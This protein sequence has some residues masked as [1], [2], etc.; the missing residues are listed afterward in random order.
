MTATG[1]PAPDGGGGDRAI[2]VTG[3][4][5]SGTSLATRALHLLGVSLGDEDQLMDAGR[6]NPAGYWENRH[7]R[8]L[9]DRLLAELGGSW[10]QPP[11]L[12][13]G[14]EHERRLDGLREEAAELLRSAFGPPGQRPATWGFKDPRLCLLLPF[15]ETVAPIEAT[16]VVVRDPAQVADSLHAR[17]GLAAPHS[18][19]L[20]LRHLLAATAPGRRTVLVVHHDLVG[21]LGGQLG[22]LAAALDLPPPDEA[23]VAAAVEHHDPDLQ[24][25]TR[26]AA[27]AAG[28]PDDDNPVVRLAARVFDEGRIDTAGLD[29]LV[30]DALRQGWLRSPSDAEQLQQA[31]ARAV[32]LEEHLRTQRRRWEAERRARG[33]PG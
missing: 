11:T 6:D 21:D 18:A 17:N 30:A 20:W 33:A 27:E 16:V 29:P 28:G 2:C 15:W 1:R 12:S 25:H 26:R 4:H 3:M 31:R 19:A 8:E 24:H 9:D 32:A 10:D 7:V 14:W 23:A 22:S 13:P 5:R